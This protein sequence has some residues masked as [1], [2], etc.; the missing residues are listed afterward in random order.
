MNL[1]AKLPDEVP[2]TDSKDDLKANEMD[3]ATVDRF[4]G[5]NDVYEHVSGNNQLAARD[6]SC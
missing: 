1:K 5:S 6:T 2:C 3:W 4:S